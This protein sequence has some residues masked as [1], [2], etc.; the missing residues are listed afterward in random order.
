MK[1]ILL[2]IGILL[3]ISSYSQIIQNLGEKRNGKFNETQLLKEWP[4]KG[5]EKILQIDNIGKGWS[6]AIA[7]N[8]MILVTGM[9]DTIDYFSAYNYQGELLWRS[10]FGRSWI[11]SFSDTRS[12]PTIEKDKAW[13]LSGTGNLACFNINNG[14]EIWSVDVDHKFKAT[15]DIWGTAES[16][17]IVDDL[18]ISVPAGELT[19]MVSLNKKTGETVW[20]TQ[21]LEGNRS[22]VSPILYEN[23]DVRLIIGMTTEVLFAVNPVNGEVAWQFPIRKRGNKFN[24]NGNKWPIYAN[25]PIAIG[26]KIFVTAGWDYGSIMLEISENGK[27]IKELWVNRDLDNQQYGVVEKDGFIYGSNWLTLKKGNWVCVNVESGE[28]IWETEHHNKG[29]I[30]SADNMFYL[31]DEDGFVNLVKPNPEKL[32]VVSEFKILEGSGQHWAH[33]FIKNGK[34]FIRHGNSLM[35]YQIK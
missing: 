11:K 10:P 8:D 23:E 5:P 17:L 21:N 30:V 18:I 20:Q 9:I 12:T 34:L 24:D 31:Y 15:W 2:T 32:N 29:I 6:A 16:P 27:G 35:V 7:A 33:P 28:T 4:E 1:L 19:S 22:Y 14:K 26:N 13:V 25:C 3:S